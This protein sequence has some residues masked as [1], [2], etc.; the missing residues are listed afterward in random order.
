MYCNSKH[1]K[2]QRIVL[3][4]HLYEITKQKNALANKYVI[5]KG[6]FFWSFK[7]SLNYIS[8]WK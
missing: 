7:I 2:I 4:V 6:F 1:F 3:R 5:G 8:P